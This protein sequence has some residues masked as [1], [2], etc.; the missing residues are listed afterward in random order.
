MTKYGGQGDTTE[1]DGALDAERVVAGD[2]SWLGGMTTPKPDDPSQPN[3]SNPQQVQ[4]DEDL[5]YGHDQAQGPGGEPPWEEQDPDEEETL[6]PGCRQPGGTGS[7]PYTPNAVEHHE[8]G[9]QGAEQCQDA[10][11][12]GKETGQETPERP[13]RSMGPD[14]DRRIDRHEARELSRYDHSREEKGDGANR[15]IEIGSHAYP[16]RRIYDGD[17]RDVEDTRNEESKQ[18]DS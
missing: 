9:N 12:P 18:I 17:G 5:G 4:E 1:E 16:M 2:Q 11:E 3:D 14:I 10:S 6:L 13:Q 8:Y 15:P 7:K